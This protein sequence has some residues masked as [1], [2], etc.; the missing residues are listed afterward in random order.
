M[1]RLRL[2]LLPLLRRLLCRKAGGAQ[3]L[4]MLH[5]RWRLLG[6]RAPCSRGRAAEGD[7]GAVVVQE[8]QLNRIRVVALQVVEA[9]T[10]A[11]AP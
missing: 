8:A 9:R 3:L 6:G 7:P 1:L 11:A 4:H 5:L 2:S 10:E